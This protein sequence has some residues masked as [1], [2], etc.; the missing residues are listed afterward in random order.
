MVP[1]HVDKSSDLIFTAF[2]AKYL[3]QRCEIQKKKSVSS[4]L[5]GKEWE[6]KIFPLHE[7]D[8]IDRTME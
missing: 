8:L 5:K 1:T 7:V 3:A 2:R 4:S 6:G